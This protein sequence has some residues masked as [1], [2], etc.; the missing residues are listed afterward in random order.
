MHLNRYGDS[1]GDLPLE[2]AKKRSRASSK[3]LEVHSTSILTTNLNPK[4]ILQF[5]EILSAVIFHPHNA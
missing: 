5:V 3:A 2:V 4:L 1:G